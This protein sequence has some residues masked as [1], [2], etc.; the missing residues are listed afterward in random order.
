M[1]LVTYFYFCR[2]VTIWQTLNGLMLGSARASVCSRMEGK[3]L[4]R[5]CK[6]PL[7]A[8]LIIGIFSRNQFIQV[9]KTSIP[10]SRRKTPNFVDQ[11]QCMS[12]FIWYSDSDTSTFDIWSSKKLVLGASASPSPCCSN[13]KHP[14]F[15]P[16][17]FGFLPFSLVSAMACQWQWARNQHLLLQSCSDKW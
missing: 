15:F 2:T 6:G 10:K 9:I 3:Y 16:I 8:F 17:L 14:P 4:D 7:A 11:F 1:F 5:S 13:F 12:D